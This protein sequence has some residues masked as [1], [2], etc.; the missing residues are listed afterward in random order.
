MDTAEFEIEGEPVSPLSKSVELVGVNLRCKGC[1][2]AT[3][4]W[5]AITE[6]LIT[7]YDKTTGELTMTLKLNTDYGDCDHCKRM[8]V[9]KQKD[10][11]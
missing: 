11:S 8:F 1:S 4:N 3:F 5:L 9:T 10:S 7:T 6:R 2:G